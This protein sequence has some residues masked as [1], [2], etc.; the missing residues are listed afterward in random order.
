MAA[1]VLSGAARSDGPTRLNAPAHKASGHSIA[2][3]A[4]GVGFSAVHQVPEDQVVDVAGLLVTAE[5]GDMIGSTMLIATDDDEKK[6]PPQDLFD[7]IET[8]RIWPTW[9]QR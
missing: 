4:V 5:L 7:T 9:Q 8:D 3:E 1:R 6:L 2:V